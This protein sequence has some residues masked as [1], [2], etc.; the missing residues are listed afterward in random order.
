MKC[1]F[2]PIAL[3]VASVTVLAGCSSVEEAGRTNNAPKAASLNKA[4]SCTEVFRLLG[5]STDET[6]KDVPDWASL[7]PEWENLAQNSSDSEIRE[8]AG[9]I[10][11]ALNKAAN[12]ASVFEGISSYTY[13]I[14]T[15]SQLC[16]PSR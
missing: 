11:S 10:V 4:T 8:S 7:V 9:R 12:E 2:R 5:K 15:I 6:M 1:R 3:V 14:L 13:E 16:P